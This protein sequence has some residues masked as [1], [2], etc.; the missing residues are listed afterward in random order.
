MP[1]KRTSKDAF[2]SVVSRNLPQRQKKIYDVLLS[3]NKPLTNNE[4]SFISRLPINVV[5]PRT[6][7]LVRDGI[8]FNAG[9]RKCTRTGYNAVTWYH[10]KTN[11]KSI[12]AK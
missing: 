10:T 11:Q 12:D 8:L 2:F 1:V 3:K 5:T 9:I 4:I 7:E 6:N